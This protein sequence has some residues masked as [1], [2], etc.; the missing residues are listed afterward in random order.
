MEKANVRVGSGVI[1]LNQNN[2]VLLGH[3]C[4]KKA[5][6]GG[7]I[8]RDTWSLP[9]GKQEFG[10]TIINCITREA[11]EE[12]NLD[13][14]NPQLLQVFD[15]MEPDR[16]FLTVLF[17]TREYSG[18]PMVMEIEKEDEWGWFNLNSLPENLY[19]PSRKCLEFYKSMINDN[20]RK[21]EKDIYDRH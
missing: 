12:C 11:K 17:M 3:R 14:F 21:R 6:T 8:G 15:D 5:D 2:E 20:G 9:G 4:A 16:H 1:I 19:E 10:E 18:E 13:I 7:I